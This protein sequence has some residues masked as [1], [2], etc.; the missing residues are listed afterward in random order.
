MQ[1]TGSDVFSL[2]IP[3]ELAVYA[4]SSSEYFRRLTRHEIAILSLRR[5]LFIVVKRKTGEVQ[6][7]RLTC[8]KQAASRT[9]KSCLAPPFAKANLTIKHH[10]APGAVRW[11][12]RF[13]RAKG[14]RMSNVTRIATAH[15]SD[16]EY[17]ARLVAVTTLADQPQ[18]AQA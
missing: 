4:G 8:T 5:M 13:D 12:T 17:T 14:G 16:A 9:L 18:L 7:A 10:Q 15:Q 2:D 3:L 1:I 6:H 11:I